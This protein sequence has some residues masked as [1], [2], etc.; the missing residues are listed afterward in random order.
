MC[1]TTDRTKHRNGRHQ[2]ARI[3]KPGEIFVHRVR[4][5]PSITPRAA[6]EA[7]PIPP[8]SVTYASQAEVVHDATCDLCDSRILGVR[9]KCT[10]CPDYDVCSSC[11]L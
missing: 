7:P 3:T 9:H 8:D 2:F 5:E 1:W 10:R 6:T 4:E 11:F